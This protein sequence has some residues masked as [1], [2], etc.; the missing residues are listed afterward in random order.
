MHAQAAV[1]CLHGTSATAL[2]SIDPCRQNY[3][4]LAACKECSHMLVT[5]A[6]LYAKS[7]VILSRMPSTTPSEYCSAAMTSMCRSVVPHPVKTIILSWSTQQETK[8]FAQ[9]SA[10]R[11]LLALQGRNRRAL[12]FCMKQELTHSPDMLTINAHKAV[13]VTRPS[14]PSLL[15]H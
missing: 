6:M 8:V 4:S 2:Y 7:G 15:H 5:T 1:E 10:H 12:L 9:I 14:C 11:L 13:S 3:L